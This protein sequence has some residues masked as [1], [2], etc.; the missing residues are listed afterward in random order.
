MNL[1]SYGRGLFCPYF[2][3]QNISDHCDMFYLNVVKLKELQSIMKA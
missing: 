1:N 3:L 2:Y